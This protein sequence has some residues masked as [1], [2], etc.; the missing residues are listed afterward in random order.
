MNFWPDTHHSLLERLA[1]PADGLA[2]QHFEDCYQS[3]I[4]RLAR[5]RGLQ[6]EEAKDVVQEVFLAVHRR[7]AQWKP[8]GHPGSF[9]A[10][11]AETT[12]RHVFASLRFREKNGRSL[13]DVDD[14][15]APNAVH[16]DDEYDNEEYDN[17]E[18]GNEEYGNDEN[19]DNEHGDGEPR[20]KELQEWLFYQAVAEIEK[21]ANPQHWKAFW[22]TAIEGVDTAT[23][24]Q[25]LGLKIGTIYSIRS[26]LLG[27][28][29]ERIRSLGQ[30]GTD[31]RN[32]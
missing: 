22:M 11:L 17:E 15:I 12:R 30:I 5:S 6:P 16:G 3:A 21:E 29:K 18:Y 14:P 28:I 27:L 24:A 4:Y 1:D 32:S 13:L 26:R 8:S 2:W 23:A 25:T 31:G 20:G 7:A 19:G 9:R 10:W